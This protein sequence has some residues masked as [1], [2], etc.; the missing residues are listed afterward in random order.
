LGFR[1]QGANHAFTAAR[2]QPRPLKSP[3]KR[4]ECC[5]SFFSYRKKLQFR[6]EQIRPQYPDCIAYR[7]A[8][9]DEK[10][11][12]IEFEFKS[13]NFKSHKHDPKDCDCIVCRHH[14]W[15][16]SPKQI[17]IIELKR[18]FGVGVKVWIQPA[19]KRCASGKHA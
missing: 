13:S 7:K 6:I 1:I 5:F 11:I 12:R 14:D 15:P 18:H 17:E 16:D 19:V 9:N 4:I 10:R 3:R 8:G 2:K